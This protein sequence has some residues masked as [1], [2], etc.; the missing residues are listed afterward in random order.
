MIVFVII[1]LVIE[2]FGLAEEL[3]LSSSYSLEHPFGAIPVNIL[4]WRAEIG[5]F[6]SKLA[7]YPFKFNYRANACEI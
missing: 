7:K 1:L 6:N 5:I 4:Q 3:R 2:I